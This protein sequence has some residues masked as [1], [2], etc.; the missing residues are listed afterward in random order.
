[1]ISDLPWTEVLSQT[2][3]YTW[4]LNNCIHRNFISVEELLSDFLLYFNNFLK[5]MVSEMKLCSTIFYCLND[6]LLELPSD[7]SE[8]TPIYY[9]L[10][11][12]FL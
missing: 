8:L 2:N 1:M 9:L 12:S 11:D 7:F 5:T 6:V 10:I 4:Y 3:S